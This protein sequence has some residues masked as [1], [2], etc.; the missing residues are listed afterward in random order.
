M[1]KVKVVKA[2]GFRT[3]GAALFCTT[4]HMPASVPCQQTRWSIADQEDSPEC[5]RSLVEIIR[6]LAEHRTIDDH[7]RRASPYTGQPLVRKQ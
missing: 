4:G 3:A 5:D 1:T 6:G 7:Q 2:D